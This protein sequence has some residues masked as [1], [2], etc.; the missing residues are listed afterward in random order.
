MNVWNILNV[1]DTGGN[2]FYLGPEPPNV[3]DIKMEVDCLMPDSTHC[4][5]GEIPTQVARLEADASRDVEMARHE[6]TSAGYTSV[7]QGYASNSTCPGGHAGRS[8]IPIKN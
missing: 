3:S 2:I 5:S 1:E 8:C 7:G 4:H 6:W